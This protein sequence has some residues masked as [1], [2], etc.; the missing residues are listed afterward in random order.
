MHKIHLTKLR[1]PVLLRRA[2]TSTDG[3]KYPALVFFLL[4]FILLCIMSQ[5]MIYMLET[6]INCLL[7]MSKWPLGWTMSYTLPQTYCYSFLHLFP[8]TV[9]L[10]HRPCSSSCTISVTLSIC[11]LLD[12]ADWHHCWVNAITGSKTN[13]GFVNQ[14]NT[15]HSSPLCVV[16]TFTYC[17]SCAKWHW[18]RLSICLV[19]HCNDVMQKHTNMA[20][21]RAV[22]LQQYRRRSLSWWLTHYHHFS[23]MLLYKCFILEKHTYYEKLG[24]TLNMLF[25]VVGV[26]TVLQREAVQTVNL[27]T[28]VTHVPPAM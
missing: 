11:Q 4:I 18:P 9:F 15:F 13:Q 26:L 23:I 27:V 21:V 16:C 28:S 17:A 20:D 7:Q 12:A 10:C 6:W 19:T 5:Y 14:L 24:L 3:C 1:A 25:T 2:K 22:K 8:P